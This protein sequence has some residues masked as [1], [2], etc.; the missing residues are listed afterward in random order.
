MYYKF[1]EI[2]DRVG[3]DASLAAY[4]LKHPECLPG[5]PKG[6]HRL[7]SENQAFLL[8]IYTLLLQNGRDRWEAAMTLAAM[9]HDLGNPQ[10]VDTGDFVD[11]VAVGDDGVVIMQCKNGST[12]SRPIGKWEISG[13]SGRE[14]SKQ[15]S[16]KRPK[17]F[18]RAVAAPLHCTQI[19]LAMLRELLKA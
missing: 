16:A 7:F 17:K 13:Y 15:T 14:R 1:G 5:M 12:K 9:V 6:W 11:G 18:R 3:I 4:A 19:N 10:F 2:I 8:S